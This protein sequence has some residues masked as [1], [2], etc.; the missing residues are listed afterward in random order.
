M[1]RGRENRLRMKLYPL[2][3]QRPVAHTHDDAA[4]ATGAHLQYGRQAIAPNRQRVVTRRLNGRVDAGEYAAPIVRDPRHLP[5]Q[6]LTRALDHTAKHLPDA[7]MPQAHT[8]NRYLTGEVA[9][10]FFADA[11]LVR[12]PRSGRDD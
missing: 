1:P 4:L 11:R 12:I 5:V 10:G 3:R 7:L 8:E 2:D 6:D 9:D